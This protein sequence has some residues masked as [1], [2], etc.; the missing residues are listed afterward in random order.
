MH[1]VAREYSE[2]EVEVRAQLL[3]SKRS[4]R[5]VYGGLASDSG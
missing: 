5:Q 3:H 2:T 4:N 1:E